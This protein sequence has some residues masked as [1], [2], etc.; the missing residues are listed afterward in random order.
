MRCR[1]EF[2]RTVPKLGALCAFLLFAGAALS[3]QSLKVNKLKAL[4]GRALPSAFGRL[5]NTHLAKT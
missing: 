1:M 3:A 2:R 4:D 5:V